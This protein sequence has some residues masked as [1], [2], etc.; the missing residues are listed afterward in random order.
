[1]TLK[2]PVY[3]KLTCQIS[4]LMF[5]SDTIFHGQKFKKQKMKNTLTP[6][7]LIGSSSC[8][9]AAVMVNDTSVNFG[10]SVPEGSIIAST[11]PLSNTTINPP[12]PTRVSYANYDISSF[13]SAIDTLALTFDLTDFSG[14][15][16]SL[17]SYTVEYLGTSSVDDIPVAFFNIPSAV[18]SVTRTGADIGTSVTVEFTGINAT[19]T[20]SFALFKFTALNAADENQFEFSNTS[21]APE[22][23][24]SALLGL[25]AISMLLRRRR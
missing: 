19:L 9:F 20:D 3:S 14:A 12:K 1:M 25:G 24:S 22:P 23:S 8:A 10:A 7:I 18:A 16:T 6:L 13:S 11:S 4:Y 5:F 17:D 21:L 15:N 2:P